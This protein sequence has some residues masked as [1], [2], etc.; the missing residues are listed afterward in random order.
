MTRFVMRNEVANLVTK[1]GNDIIVKI[2]RDE[3]KFSV[4]SREQIMLLAQAHAYLRDPES[5]VSVEIYGLTL[6]AKLSI[7]ALKSLPYSLFK[8]TV[9]HELTHAYLFSYALDTGGEYDMDDEEVCKIMAAYAED[10]LE[11]TEMVMEVLA[12]DGCFNEEDDGD[13]V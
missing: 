2:H 12:E 1:R 3:W 8:N 10:I 7:M 6:P 13:D 4:E 11:D 9:I 5:D